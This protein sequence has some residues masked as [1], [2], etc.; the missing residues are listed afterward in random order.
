M[1]ILSRTIFRE[2]ATGA[3]FGVV[4]FTFVLFLRNTP[5]LFAI[6]V[7]SSAP[8]KTVAYLFS[9]ALP[10]ALTFTVPLGVLVGVLLGLSRMSGDGEITAMRAS[11]I[12]GRVVTRPVLVLA[13]LATLGAAA[14]SLWLTPWSYREHYRILNKLAAEELTA[15][16][17]PRVFDEQFP[18]RI[19][20]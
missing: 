11:G 12:P 19:L 10:Q 5:Q 15:E 9:L 14:C 3:F 18:N 7:R 20:Y 2:I 17:Q 16:I 6:L 4:L 13:G 1:R 8:P